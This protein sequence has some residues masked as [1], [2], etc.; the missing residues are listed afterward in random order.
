MYYFTKM[1]N[2]LNIFFGYSLIDQK[3]VNEAGIWALSGRYVAGAHVWNDIM[4]ILIYQ[5]I[6]LVLVCEKVLIRLY[7]NTC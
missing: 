2:V 6:R 5:S 1:Y 3:Q 7:R 4:Y